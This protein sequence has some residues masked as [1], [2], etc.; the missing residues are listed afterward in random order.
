MSLLGVLLLAPWLAVLGWA[1]WACTRRHAVAGRGPDA[2]ALVLAAIVAVAL[3][4]TAFAD[5]APVYGPMWK[6]IFAALAAY[7][8]FVGVL[9]VALLARRFGRRR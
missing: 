9:L 8:G 1:Y 3:S 5:A 4:L 7:G 2:A 6:F